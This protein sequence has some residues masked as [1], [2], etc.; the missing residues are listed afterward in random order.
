MRAS[1]GS[2]HAGIETRGSVAS[3]LN[4]RG[5]T[6]EEYGPNEGES[7]DYPDVSHRVAA[8]VASGASSLGV[9]ICGTGQGMAM[10]ANRH[11]GIRAAVLS[12][13]FTAEMARAHNDANLACFGER[14]VGTE[15]I[16]EFLVVFLD[17]E[18]E[19]GR[20]RRRVEKIDRTPSEA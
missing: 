19:G 17:T 6:V 11:P 18:F 14:V 15:R 20:H 13:A 3:M 4:D 9:L 16:L 10:A 8:D 12:D 2:D 7:A 1:I 5:Y